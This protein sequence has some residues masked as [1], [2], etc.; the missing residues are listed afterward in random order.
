MFTAGDCGLSCLAAPRCAAGKRSGNF[1]TCTNHISSLIISI[2][3]WVL[4]GS[5]TE[6]VFENEKHSEREDVEYP[7]INKSPPLRE[8]SLYCTKHQHVIHFISRYDLN[9]VF[10]FKSAVSAGGGDYCECYCKSS[11]V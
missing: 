5:V 4:S 3:C 1:C 6:V 8:I 2:Y 7:L 11:M 10:S 9:L